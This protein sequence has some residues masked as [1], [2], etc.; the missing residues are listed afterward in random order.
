MIYLK[1]ARIKYSNRVAQGENFIQLQA[2][3]ETILMAFEN[4]AEFDRWAQCF[5]YQQ[6][7]IES[8]SLH[9][10]QLESASMALN[11]SGMGGMMSGGGMS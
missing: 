8:E 9:R 10:A 5:Q 7:Q 11:T 1:S 6:R 4:V 2:N 3:E